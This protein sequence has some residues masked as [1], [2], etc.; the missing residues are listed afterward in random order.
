VIRRSLAD[1]VSDLIASDLIFSDRIS[2]GELLPSEKDLA[3]M[4]GASRITV[5]QSLRTL[6]EAGL[7]RVKHGVGSTVLPRGNVVNYGLDR[8]GSIETFARESGGEVVSEDVGFRQ[9]TA[10]NELA[11]TLDVEVGHRVLEV[12]RAKSYNGVR[13][14]WLVDY[15]PEKT[16]PFE[17][18]ELEFAGSVLDVLLAHPEVGVEY[19]DLEIQA[20]AADGDTAR[21]LQSETGTAVMFMDERVFTAS[22]A[23]VERG[24]GWHLQQYRRFVLRR[25]RW[26]GA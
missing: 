20:V 1:E 15:V 10:D 13:V 21:R 26:I 24:I 5:R 8:L 22:G 18:L 3:D 19:A 2:P 14:A 23:V 11:D 12:S 7:I 17:T 16:L 25:R 9:L 6:R 4:Y